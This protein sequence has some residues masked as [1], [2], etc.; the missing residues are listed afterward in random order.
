M[1]TA[2][3]GDYAPSH[4]RTGLP[5]LFGWVMFDWSTQPFYTLITTFLFAP[6]FTSFFVGD[7]RGAAWWGYA[8]GVA[9]IIV[10][11]SSPLIGAMADARGRVKPYIAVFGAGFVIAQALLWYAEPGALDRLWLIVGALIVA[12]CC[13]EFITVL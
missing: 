9:A 11:I 12:T 10:A 13:A 6:Y 5:G 1:T 4:R 2:A 3:A 7:E 8:M